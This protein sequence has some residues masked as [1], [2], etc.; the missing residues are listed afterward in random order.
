MRN[1][2]KYI[3]VHIHTYTYIYKYMYIY[4][5]VFVCVCVFLLCGAVGGGVGVWCGVNGAKV[6]EQ[7]V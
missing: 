3:Q 6:A 1:I 4:M 2:F 7:I 5:C